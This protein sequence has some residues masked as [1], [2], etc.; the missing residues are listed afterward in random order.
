VTRSEGPPVRN[1]HAGD[2]PQLAEIYAHHVRHGLATFEL[3][4]PDA[5]EMARRHAN[6]VALG[7]PYLVAD[8]DGR[9]A[10]YAYASP[11]R[12]RPAYRF[13]VEDSI[14][15]RHDCA[16]HGIGSVLLPALIAACEAAGCRQ[17]VAVIGDSANHA[18]IRLHEKFGFA[19]AGLLPA[20]GWK[21]GRWVDSVLM[22]RALGAGDAVPPQDQ[23]RQGN[24]CR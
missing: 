18:S 8:V 10:G 22:Q 23:D 15:L 17:M 20:V 6:V 24:S 14:Y 9:I 13:T 21:F 4:P 12:T 2:I 3:D 19:H 1:A 7:L 5:A 16:G 11:Y